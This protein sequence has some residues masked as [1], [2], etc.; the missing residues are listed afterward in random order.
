MSA[1]D[2]GGAGQ[3]WFVR[4]SQFLRNRE[5]D[6]AGPADLPPAD[7]ARIPPEFVLLDAV[8]SGMPDPV[9]VLDQDGR[10]VAFNPQA[11]PSRP[12]CAAASRRRLRCACPSWSRRSAPRT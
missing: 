7:R 3:G 8:V 6:R 2:D 11:P 5:D 1:T 4:L 12:R 9:T 10:V